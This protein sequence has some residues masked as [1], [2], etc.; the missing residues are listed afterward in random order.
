MSTEKHEVSPVEE[1]VAAPSVQSTLAAS[2]PEKEKEPLPVNAVAEGPQQ[3][4]S[5]A[6]LAFITLGLCLATF[7]VA[8]DNTIIATAIPTI[9]V[10]FDSLNDVGW[11]GSSYLLTLTSLQP[12]FGKIYA[13]FDLKYTYLVALFIF[14]IGSIICAAA[15][16]STMLIVG[17]AV[18]G[19]G[20][21]AIFSGGMIIIGYSVAIEKRAIYVA[22]LSSMFG[23]ASVVGPLLGGVFTDKVSWRWCFWINLPFGAIA[24]AAVFF[25]FKTPERKTNTLT[26]KEKVAQIDMLGAAFLI[27]GVTCL[28]LALQ[29]GGTVHPWKSSTIWGLF[30]GFALIISVFIFIQFRRQEMATIPPGVLKQRTVLV[31]ALF[32]AIFS[33]AMYIHIFYLPFYFQAIKGT[34]AVGSGIRTIPYLVSIT[35]SSIVVGTAIT[36]TGNYADFLWAGGL[37][38]VAGC[39]MISTLKV[40]SNTGM[41]LGYQIIAGVGGGSAVQIPFLAVQVVLSQAQTPVGTSIVMFFNSLGGAIAISIAQNIFSNQLN[42]Q[43]PIFAPDVDPALVLSAGATHLREVIPP[44]SI[45][46]VLTAYAKALDTTFIPSIAFAS[47]AVIV[48]LGIQRVNVKGKALDHA[49][50]GA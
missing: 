26:L 2:D 9:T 35:L 40:S 33:M 50:G 13:N 16:N 18:A 48:A 34:S 3:Y 45:G 24:F 25:F 38:F 17:R 28:L 15:V 19:V 5:G 32:S 7:V 41:W 31:C 22:F 1:P 37:V 29:W 8:L 47:L 39:V 6:K 36:I 12:S 21:S 11:Y 4:P 42:K 23:I 44:Q 43:L 14:E 30:L 27:A 10:K 46:G 20:A 49:A